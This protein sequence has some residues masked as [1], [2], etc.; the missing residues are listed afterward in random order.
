MFDWWEAHEEAAGAVIGHPLLHALMAIVVAWL[1]AALANVLIGGVL[2]ALA[3]RTPGDLDDKLIEV[4]HR[5]IALTV[6]LVGTWAPLDLLGLPEPAPLIKGLIVSFGTVIWTIAILR[7][8]GATL[9]ALTRN[10]KEHSLLQARTRPLFEFSFRVG[11]VGLCIYFLFLAWNIDVTAWLAS[12]GIVGVAVGFA[13]KESLANVFAGAFIIIDAPY[14]IGDYLVLEDGD[15]GRVTDIGFRSTR[16]LTDDDVQ[17]IIPNS[18]M[19]TAHIVNESGP[20]ERERVSVSVT[21]AYGVDLERVRAVVFE[22]LTGCDRLIQGDPKHPAAV[23]FRMLGEY[24]LTL[25]VLAWIF[26]PEHRDAAIDQ[27]NSA[28]YAAFNAHGI[29]FPYPRRDVHVFRGGPDALV[30]AVDA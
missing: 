15:R 7:A 6:G 27:M 10:A 16:L 26:H 3:R 21:V 8:S 23:Q 13:A 12:A 4:L 30:S 2:L 28:L 18:E 19:A 29:S 17:V 14:R 22:A 25:Q 9:D 1:A 20:T 24:G 11:L 5:P